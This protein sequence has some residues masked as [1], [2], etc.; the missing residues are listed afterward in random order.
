MSGRLGHSRKRR[1]GYL[2]CSNPVD[3]GRSLNN[4][5]PRIEKPERSSPTRRRNPEIPAAIEDRP[6]KLLTTRHAGAPAVTRRHRPAPAIVHG[7]EHLLARRNRRSELDQTGGPC[8][9]RAELHTQVTGRH[10]LALWVKSRKKPAKRRNLLAPS[11]AAEVDQTQ[12]RPAGRQLWAR[13]QQRRI[14]AESRRSAAATNAREDGVLP[15]L[16]TTCSKTAEGRSSAA[17]GMLVAALRREL[18][19]SRYIAT[20][21]LAMR[22]C[23]GRSA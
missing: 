12:T 15:R 20:Q 9:L 8:R 2:S 11:F 16:P 22:R 14:Y 1:P 7:G 6:G 4:S 3:A 17:V 19:K 18:T 10:G 13:S 5:E 23:S 21:P